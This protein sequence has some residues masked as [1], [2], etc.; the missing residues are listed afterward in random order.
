MSKPSWFKGKTLL[1]WKRQAKQ[2]RIVIKNSNILFFAIAMVL[3][4]MITSLWDNQTTSYA[5][6]YT[7]E[8]AKEKKPVSSLFENDVKLFAADESESQAFKKA[9]EKEIARQEKS[10]NQAQSNSGKSISL[11]AYQGGDKTKNQNSIAD[12]IANQNSGENA[13]SRLFAEK[14]YGIVGDTP[15]KEMVPFISQRDEKVAAFLVGIAKKESSF[16]L[17][18][19]SKDGETCFNYWGYKGQGQRGTGMGYACFASPEE[20]IKVVGDRIEVLVNKQRN[21]PARMVDT[22]KFGT[23]CAG[24]PGAPSWVATVALYFEKIVG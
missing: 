23:S 16:G 15:I 8:L 14:L 10:D 13:E 6:A 24:D 9:E 21:T 20:A 5:Y 7:G 1:K 19:P 18:S 12:I 4:A 3:F 2:I 22:W 11:F 17:A